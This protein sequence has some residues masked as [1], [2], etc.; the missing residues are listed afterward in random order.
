MPED[1]TF[2]DTNIIIDAIDICLRFGYSSWESM[3][4]EAA[5]KGGATVLISKD[6]QDGQVVSGVTIKNPF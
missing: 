6:L 4:V 3:I 2:I 5:I 1:K